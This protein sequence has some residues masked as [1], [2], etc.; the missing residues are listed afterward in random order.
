M[1]AFRLDDLRRHNPGIVGRIVVSKRLAAEA[2]GDALAIVA[3][4]VDHLRAGL[5]VE[6]GDVGLPVAVGL[7]GRDDAI[8]QNRAVDQDAEAGDAVLIELV[9]LGDREP[10]GP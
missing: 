8:E 4:E 2:L 7:V 5:N 10:V 1:N 6:P 3:H 9:A